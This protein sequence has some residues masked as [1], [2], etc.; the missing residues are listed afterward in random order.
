MPDRPLWTC[1]RCGRTFANRNQSHTCAALGSIEVH[2][3]GKDPTVRATF[4]RVLEVLGPVGRVDVLHL[5][6]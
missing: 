1:P 5:I 4:D 2:F 6:S 3:D